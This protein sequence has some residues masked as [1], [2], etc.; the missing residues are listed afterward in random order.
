MLMSSLETTG[1]RW[2]SMVLKILIIAIIMS[3]GSFRGDLFLVETCPTPEKFIQEMERRFLE[4][5]LMGWSAKCTDF[6]FVPTD[7][8]SKRSET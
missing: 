3:D 8:K 7:L 5:D 4:E 6:E 2:D 1:A